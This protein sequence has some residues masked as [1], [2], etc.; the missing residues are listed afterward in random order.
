MRLGQEQRKRIQQRFDDQAFNGIQWPERAKPSWARIVRRLNENRFDYSDIFRTKPALIDTG[1]LKRSIYFKVRSAKTLEFGS[2]SPYS[3]VHN[4][5]G[6]SS[7]P[8]LSSGK[9]LLSNLI[10]GNEKIGS[11]LGWLMGVD[12]ISV[13]VPKRQFLGITKNDVEHLGNIAR[14]FIDDKLER[15]SK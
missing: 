2:I 14:Q 9:N 12:E 13:N 1:K 7:I 5:G 4:E 11:L 3:K 8:F 10:A 15:E 6:V